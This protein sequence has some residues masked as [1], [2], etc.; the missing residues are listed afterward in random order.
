[1]YTDR[2]LNHMSEPFKQVMLDI[3][4]TM[5]EAYNAAAT[6]VI[7]GSGTYGM[8]AVARQFASGKKAVVLRNGYFSFR[9]TQIFEQGGI[10]TSHIVAKARCVSG[11]GP[12]ARYAP[13]P[14]DE[15]E[16][17]IAK[18]KPVSDARAHTRTAAERSTRRA[19][20]PGP[21]P[22]PRHPTSPYQAVLFAP[23]VETS[24]G[25]LL[26][27]DYVTRAAKAVHD[28][29]GLMVLDCIASGTLWVDMEALGVDAL[30]T[31]PQKGW[32]GEAE[33]ASRCDAQRS[34]QRRA[35]GSPA[36]PSRGAQA[37][38]APAS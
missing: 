13:M 16:A 33:I 14:I 12:A 37:P 1:M 26:P 5:K 25:I 24:T 35:R 6:I 3:S 29:G 18:E 31:A 27:D 21:A 23:H 28:A 19:S 8:E 9:W 2:A 15:L 10:P 17:L 32:S 30:I 36:H 7:P 38:R 34:A 4:S 22:P 11:D 20:R